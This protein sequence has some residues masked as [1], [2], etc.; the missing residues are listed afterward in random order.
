MNQCWPSSLTHIC[1]TR[2]GM[3]QM[4]WGHW[5]KWFCKCKPY[6]SWD[7]KIMLMFYPWHS[8]FCKTFSTLLKIFSKV[9]S[10]YIL[11]TMQINVHTWLNLKVIVA[12]DF[13]LNSWILK[14]VSCWDDCSQQDMDEIIEI[15]IVLHINQ[16]V[17]KM[18]CKFEWRRKTLLEENAHGSKMLAILSEGAKV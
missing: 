1:G 8:K 9:L 11:A 14:N 4:F 10:W 15:S 3:G 2:W 17:N 6:H 13:T 7:T 12:V 16:F 18:Y 5:C